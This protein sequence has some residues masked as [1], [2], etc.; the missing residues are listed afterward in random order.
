MN[1]NIGVNNNSQGEQYSIT[2]REGIDFVTLGMVIIGKVH[3]TQIPK[4]N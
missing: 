1:D 2:G 4:L 3:H